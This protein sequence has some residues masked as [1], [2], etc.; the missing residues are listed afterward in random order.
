MQDPANDHEET[1]TV[2]QAR[3]NLGPLVRW[4]A[5]TGERLLITDRGR[6]AAVLVSV[7]ELARL[8]NSAGPAGQ[9]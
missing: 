9:S 6:P 7:K 8:D 2:S 5:R 1:M 4:C 3:A